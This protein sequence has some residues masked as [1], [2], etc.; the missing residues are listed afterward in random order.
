MNGI[1]MTLVSS[2]RMSS[3]SQES[4]GLS[5]SGIRLHSSSSRRP[6]AVL[7]SAACPACAAVKWS[8]LVS[9]SWSQLSTGQLQLLPN[10]VTTCKGRAQS[11][12]S[13]SA[14]HW[15]A[16][17]CPHS[18]GFLLIQKS[19]RGKSRKYKSEISLVKIKLNFSHFLSSLSHRYESLSSFSVV[20][21]KPFSS[22]SAASQQTLRSLS[23][24]S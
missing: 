22:L 6:P 16:G 14:S 5:G 20:S 12:G 24:V 15:P 10:S 4:R 23:A 17:H 2:M 11:S 1:R 21:Q 7:C 9:P 18:D 3:L 8:A 19:Q 13:A